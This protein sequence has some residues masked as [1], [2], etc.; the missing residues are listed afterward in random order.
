MVTE[1]GGAAPFSGVT[2]PARIGGWTNVAYVDRAY[3]AR[4]YGDA[5]KVN[6][7]I[8]LHERFSTNPRPWQSWVF[9][10]FELRTEARILEIG[11]GPGN[12]W[13]E[14]RDRIPEGWRLTLTDPYP[15]MLRHAE[16]RLG[17]DERFRF[18][19]ADAQD[20]P[21]AEGAFDAV[22]ANHV[23]YHVPDRD[24]ALSEIARVMK[25]NGTLYAATN[26]KDTHREMGWMQRVLDP[27]RGESGYFRDR[28][29]FSLENGHE[30][31]SRHFAD[32]SFSR[33]DDALV[34][35]ETG[36]LVEYL[37][38]GTAADTAMDKAGAEEL[39][40]RASELGERLE[41][42]LTEHGSIRIT[43]DVGLFTAR[44]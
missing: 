42:E 12:L 38:S 6:A 37:L 41:R 30:Q 35:T 8:S 25:H 21:F 18:L 23:L 27:G 5:S 13:C 29:G 7:R 33:Y 31:L 32:V 10:R 44:A 28:L 24:C 17:P 20:L 36:P 4:Q 43:K 14:S 15:G 19:F 34:V 16:G 22:V 1:A 26:G 11:C 39:R 9:D 40:Q 3:V 2:R